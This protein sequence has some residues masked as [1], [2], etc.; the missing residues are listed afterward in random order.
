MK[1]GTLG[2]MS[3]RRPLPESDKPSS[4]KATATIVMALRASKGE[5]RLSQPENDKSGAEDGVKTEPGSWSSVL[6]QPEDDR[7][8]PDDVVESVKKLLLERLF[9]LEVLQ[10]RVASTMMIKSENCCR[11][12]D[13]SLGS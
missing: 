10:R 2:E 6:F 7:A 12:I 13:I 11:R 4:P 9:E 5:P 8:E 1:F 3:H